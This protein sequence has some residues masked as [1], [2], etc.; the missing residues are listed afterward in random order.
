ML[1]LARTTQSRLNV[2]EAARTTVS[3]T[4]ETAPRRTCREPGRIGHELDLTLRTGEPVTVEKIAALVTSRDLAI[5]E[6][7]VTAARA[8]GRRADLR[9]PARGDHELAWRPALAP[10][11]PRPHRRRDPAMRPPRRCAD[12]APEHLP[13]PADGLRRTTVD[14]DAGIPARGLHGEAYRGHVFWDELFVFPVLTLR[15]PGLARALLRYRIRRLDAARTG[16]AGRGPRRGAMYPWQSGSDGREESQQ[17][18]PQPALRAVDARHQLP[19]APRRAGRRLQ[20][21]AVLP[22]HRRPRVPRRPRR[23]GDARDRPLLRRP[24]D[25]TTRRT[26]VTASAG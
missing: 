22:G 17:R 12:A 5:S 16:R 14:L 2:A 3:G 8:A 1:L 10:L 6:P 9:R 20:H 25:A 18:P 23:G 4:A 24:R 15:L 26:T 13:R 19:A 21:L 11:P 7:A